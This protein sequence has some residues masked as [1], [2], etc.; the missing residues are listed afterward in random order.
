MQGQLEAAPPLDPA[1]AFTP[2]APV[3]GKDSDHVT[4]ETE[5]SGLSRAFDPNRRR[6]LLS[7]NL[8]TQFQLS[9]ASGHQQTV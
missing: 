9:V 6:E 2:V 4:G 5:G 1:V 8:G 3:S 7:G